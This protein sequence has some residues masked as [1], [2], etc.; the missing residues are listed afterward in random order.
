L[1]EGGGNKLEIK[2]VGDGNTEIG[3]G[4]YNNGETIINCGKDPNLEEAGELYGACAEE[5]FTDAVTGSKAP[6]KNEAADTEFDACGKVVGGSNTKNW[7]NTAHPEEITSDGWVGGRDQRLPASSASACPG[8]WTVVYSFTQTFTNEGKLTAESSGTFQVGLP[9]A[10]TPEELYAGKN[11]AEPNYVQSFAGDPV[12]CGTG[13]ETES[14]TDLSVK[15][16]GVPLA[17]TRTYNAQAA[18]AGKHGP[19]GYGWNSSFSDHLT[20]LSIEESSFVTVVQANGSTVDFTGNGTP[21][22]LRG[23]AQAQAKLALNEDGTYTYTLPTQ[24]SFH[25]SSSGLLLSEAD[26]DGN[27]TTMNRNT[28]G[29]LESV[30]D[31]AGRKMTFAYNTEGMLESVKDPMGHTVKYTYEGG[32]L[33]SV[34]LPGEGGP[35]WQFKYDSAHRL[36]KLTDGRGGT[37]TSEYDG[38]NRVVSQTDPAERTTTFEYGTSIEKTPETK[39]I[40]HATGAVTKEVFTGGYEPMSITKGFGTASAT[41]ERFAYDYA[42]ALVRHTDGDA[43][44]TRN[45]YDSEGNRTSMTVLEQQ[46]KWT[47]DSTHD[48]LTMT[49]PT[50][51]TTTTKRDSHGKPEVI[52]RPAPGGKIEITKYKYNSLGKL[53]SVTD[54]LERTWKYEYDSQGDRVAELDPE[55][56]KRS[57]EYNEDSQ[58]TATVSPRGN[59]VGGEPAKYTMKTERDEQGR[60]LTVTDPLGHKTKYA[61]NGNGGLE[62]STDANGNRTKY[63]YDAD[64]GLTKTEQPNG[65]FTETGYDGT[66][67]VISQTDGSKHT[68]KYVRNALE[69]AVEVIDPKERKTLKEYDKAGNLIK[70]TDPSKRIT[71]LTYDGGNRL[72][73]ISYSDGKTHAVEYEYNG[74]NQQTHITDGGGETRYTYD[75]LNRLIESK[76]GHGNVIKYEY[77]LADELTKM[78]YPNGKAVTRAYDKDGRLEKATDWLE[79]TTKFAYDRDSDLVTTTFPTSTSDVDAYAYNE[80]GQMSEVKMTKGTETLATLAY[81]RDSNGQLKATASKGLPGE[82]KPSYEYDANSRLT[83]AGITGYEYDAANNPTKVGSGTY[84]YDTASELESGA[85]SKYAYNEVGERSKLTPATGAATTY[86]Y[87][88]NGNLIAIEKLK[89]GKTAGTTDTFTYDGNNSRVSQTISG[90]KSYLAWQMNVATPLIIND[91]TYSY[92]YGPANLPIEQITTTGTVTYLHHDQQG[93]TRLLTGLTGTVTGS[94]TFDAYGSKT[95]STGTAA[96]PLG[97]AAQYTSADTGLIYMRARVYDPASGQFLTVDPLDKMTRAPYNYVEDSPVNA[98]DPTGLCSDGSLSGFLDCFNPVSSGN[99]AYRGAVALNNATGINLP[100]LLT[101]PAVVDLGAAGVCVTPLLSA[102]CPLAIGAA[103]SVSTSS[104]VANGIETNF[105]KPEQLA[106]EEGVTTLLAGFGALGVYTTGAAEATGAPGYARSIIRGV[107]A[108]LEALLNGPLAANGG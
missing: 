85:G 76:D 5:V 6:S 44:V 108:A 42:G 90:T 52:E 69:Q 14:Q 24:E 37:A 25:F 7:A 41:T 3:F 39:I 23:G 43:H 53:E 70:L 30:T 104:I 71:T 11:P 81:T 18:A 40:N 4:T 12:N 51:E 28:E 32:N 57:W 79:H 65:A 59:A 96:T 36:T 84:T 26:R 72:T 33:S 56:N 80:A 54:P 1:V 34:T 48:M 83:K 21:G 22:A 93:S 64:N 91:G 20:F 107:P 87:D 77:D 89:E 60:P 67:Q 106:G 15:G 49:T 35:R 27:T 94:T 66:G 74:N 55:G 102:A 100:G 92:I 88:E 103:W 63:T 98:V 17:F 47:Y 58:G 2:D 101:K 86:T 105:C 29:R 46:T 10:A 19:V 82:E 68:M 38:S 97:Y 50:G 45:G 13:N 8:T 73:G 99:L 9:P 16:L 95:G 31:A 75:Q 78:T 62:T 61:Y